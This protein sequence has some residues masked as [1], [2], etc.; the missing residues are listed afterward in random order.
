MR[1]VADLI[2]TDAPLF[3]IDPQVDEPADYEGTGVLIAVTGEGSREMAV[4]MSAALGRKRRNRPVALIDADMAAPYLGQR[5]AARES[6]SGVVD[7]L[8]VVK[9]L[10]EGENTPAF[11][12]TRFKLRS[13][14]RDTSPGRLVVGPRPRMWHLS[15]RW[16][17]AITGS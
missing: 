1:A 17:E 8:S 9:R 6:P 14:V 12:T 7:L 11:G 2:G 15:W 13:G 3:D 5:L 4:G 16:E 10:R